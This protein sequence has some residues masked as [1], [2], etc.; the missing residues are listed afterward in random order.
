MVCRANSNR[1]LLASAAWSLVVI[2]GMGGC[3]S[4]AMNLSL[5]DTKTEATEVVDEATSQSPLQGG[6][7]WSQWGGSATHD[8]QTCARGQ[9]PSNVLHHIEYDPF[10]FQEIAEGEG[11]L[12]VHYQ[13]PLN[14]NQGNFYMMQKGGTYTSCDPPASGT[15]FPCGFDRENIVKQTWSENKYRRKANGSFEEVWSFESD[16]KPFPVFLWEPMFQPALAGPLLYVPGAGGS[17]WQVLTTFNRPIVLQRI[18]PFPTIDPNTYVTSGVTVDRFGFLYWNVVRQDPEEF[19]NRGFLVKAAPWG[20]TWIVDYETLIPDAPAAF[21]PCFYT[22]AFETP[23]PP[24]PFPPSADALPPQFA[25]GR[26]RPGVNVTPAIDRD[27]TIITASTAD[28]A[29]GYSYII[30]LKPDLSLK[31]ATSLRGLVNDGCGVERVDSPEGNV[32]CSSTFSAIGVDPNTNM[33]P[34]LNVDDA[35][36]STPV[37][38]PDGGVLY[39]ALDNYN[40]ARGHLVKLDRDGRFAG[41]YTFGWDSTPA[42][43]EHDGTYSIVVKDNHYFSRGPFYVTQLSKDLEVEW[44]FQ[45]T[46]TEACAKQPDGTI[47]CVD[48]DQLGIEWCVN[49]PAVDARGNVYANAEDGYVYQIGQGGVLKTQTFLSQALGA[50]YTP[51]SLDSQGRVFVLNNGELTVFGR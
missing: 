30:A 50:A 18:N 47:E 38:L 37:I 41:T 22:F 34:A 29:P 33:P 6:C 46:S 3:A 24:R 31:W 35:S 17:V 13:V 48:I 4:D 23:R 44:K 15:P 21:D 7:T 11:L 28:F 8:G 9:A 5:D 36:S 25:C 39:G 1:W 45:N 32:R 2:A 26:Q 42:I 14:D 16:W 43:Y 10:Q 40:F 27:G 12:F 51:I 49:A 19:G 20:Q